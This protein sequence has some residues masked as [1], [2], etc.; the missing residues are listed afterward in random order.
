MYLAT[1]IDITS[2]RVVGWATADHLRT[3]LVAAALDMAV[4]ARGG[5]PHVADVIF[6]SDREAS[7][8]PVSDSRNSPDSASGNRS[9]APGVCFDNSVAEA[10][11]SSL[12]RELIHGHH[13]ATR[14]QARRAVFAWINWHNR[15]RIHTSLNNL[16][17][18]QWEQHYHQR[19]PR[20]D[21]Q[22]A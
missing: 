16:S 20:N 7:T 3:E 21:Q 15:T 2:R 6:T 22:A 14:A 17:P 11:W 18:T 8:S 12:K 4:A 9:A 10:F 13:F 19:Q 5:C 1:V